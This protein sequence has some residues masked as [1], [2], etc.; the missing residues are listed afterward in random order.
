MGVSTAGTTVGVGVDSGVD[1]GSTVGV[2]YPMNM[3]SK[4]VFR[5]PLS[6]VSK[7]TDLKPFRKNSIG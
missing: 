7:E 6:N 3:I 4:S 2:G 1:V 5:A